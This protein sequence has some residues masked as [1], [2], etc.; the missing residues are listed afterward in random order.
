MLHEIGHGTHGRVRLGKDLSA[1]LAGED[2]D[3]DGGRYV[4]L[5]LG[6]H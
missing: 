6:L 1:E 2:E 4:S 5:I 3:P